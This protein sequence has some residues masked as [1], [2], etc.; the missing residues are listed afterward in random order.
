M[1]HESGV[2]SVV[3]LLCKTLATRIL[4][5]HKACMRWNDETANYHECSHLEDAQLILD[6]INE[7]EDEHSKVAPYKGIIE[8]K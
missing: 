8:W 7:W 4:E 2:I 1:F 6:F 5:E 3:S